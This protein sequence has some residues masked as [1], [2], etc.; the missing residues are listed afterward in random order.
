MKYDWKKKNSPRSEFVVAAAVFSMRLELA[1]AR[2]LEGF[3]F[4]DKVDE[5]KQV[6]EQKRLDCQMGIQMIPF[7]ASP[8]S[9]CERRRLHVYI[10]ES[11]RDPARYYCITHS[12]LI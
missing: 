3:Q 12:S 4:A 2:A 5:Y 6:Q 1:R 9:E 11:L 7:T 8:A 10:P